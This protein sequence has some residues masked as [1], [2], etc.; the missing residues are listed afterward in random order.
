MEQKLKQR[1]CIEFCVK[2]QI[3]TTETFECLIKHSPMTPQREQLTDE[4]V[5]KITDLIKE[6][7]R[8]TFLEL[9]QDTGISKTTIGR[10]VTEDLKLKKTPA[11]FIPRFL[12]NEQKL[13]RLETCE[14]MLEMTKTDLEWKDKIITGDETWVY[15]YDPEIKRQSAEWRGQGKRFE[16]KARKWT[17]GDNARP[18]TAHLVTGF[19]AKNG[20]QILP[21][22]PYSPDTAPNDFFL[23]PKLKAVL[24][25]RHFDT[26]DD[27]IEKSLLALK[28]IPKESYK[29]C[30]DNWEKR[31]RCPSA[32]MTRLDDSRCTL[33]VKH[34]PLGLTHQERE[35]LLGN[36]GASRVRCMSD[37]GRL[38]VSAFV[39]KTGS[40]TQWQADLAPKEMA[41]SD[42]R[43]RCHVQPLLTWSTNA[44]HSVSLEPLQ[45]GA[46]VHHI[47]QLSNNILRFPSYCNRSKWLI[48]FVDR[49][50][51]PS[52]PAITRSKVY[53]A[54]CVDRSKQ[55]SSPAIARS[56]VYNALCV[57]RSKQPSSPAITR[58][59]VYDALCVDRSKQPSS[60]A[61]TR[62]KVYDALCVDRSKQPSSPAITRSKVYDALCVDRSKQPSSPA[63]TRSKVYDALCVDRSKQPSSSAITRSKVYDALCVDRSKQPSSPAIT[64]SKVYDALCVDRSKQPSSPAIAR[65]KVYDAL[66]VDRSK[67]PSSSAITRSKVYDALC[68]DRSK[69][70]SSPAITRSKVYDALCVDRSKQPS[71]PAIT[72]S[73]VYDALCVDRSKQPSSPA[74]TRSKVYDALCVDRSKQPS[75]P[76]ITRSKVYDALC[77]DR[78]KQPSSPAI[79]RSKVYDALCVDR[80]KQPSSPAITRSKVYDALCVDRSKQP[81]SPAIARS[82]VYDALC[83]DR[84]KQPSSPAITRSKV[85]DALCVDRSKQPSSSA[86]TRS[87]VYD[88]LCVDRSKQPSSPAITRS[89]VYDALCVDRSKQPS[90]PAI[91]RSKVYDAL[92][93]D[94]SKQPSSP[95]ITRSKVYDAL[96]V[97]RSKQPSSPAITRSKVYDALCVDR[98]KQPSSSAI[99]RS[100]VYDALCVDR[101]KQPS[102]PAITRSKVYDAL[103]KQTAFAIFPSHETAKAALSRLHQLEILDCI[104]SVEFS[105]PS[106][107]RHFPLMSDCKSYASFTQIQPTD[108]SIQQRY[109]STINRLR[110]SGSIVITKSDK[111]NQTVILDSADYKKKM[112]D[113]LT[114]EDTFKPISEKEKTLLK[115]SFKKSLINLKNT[116]TITADQFA[117]FTGSLDKNAYIYG[118]PKMHKPGVPLRPIIAYHLSP[119]FPMAKYLKTIPPQYT[120]FS[121]NSPIACKI[122]TV[123]T[124][125][126]RIF[127]HCSL[128]IFKT[129]EKARIVSTLTKAGYPRPFI[130]RHFYDP[131]VPKTTT[132]HRATCFL[133]Y[134]A[135]SISISRILRPF[136]IKVHYNS[137]PSLSTIL[138][139]PITKSD[140][141]NLP[142]HSTGAVYVVSCQ[143][144]SSTYVGE[145]GRTTHIRLTEHKR[146]IRNKDPKS[147]MANNMNRVYPP[148][149]P[150]Q[151][152]PVM[153]PVGM[154]PAPPGG[155]PRHG[156]PGPPRQ[157]GPPAGYQASPQRPPYPAMPPRGMGPPPPTNSYGAPPPPR[158]PPQAPMGP[159]KRAGDRDGRMP[160]GGQP[161]KRPGGPL[162]GPGGPPMPPIGP[163]KKKKL[164][165]KILPQKVRDLVPESQAY[166]DLLA[167]ERKLDYTITRKR[168]DIQEALKRPMKQKRKLRIFISN[169][170]YPGKVVDG[171]E[172][173]VEEA[174]NPTGGPV[175]SWELRVEGRLLEDILR[176]QTATAKPDQS[177][178][179]RK[180]SSF[181]KSLVIELDKDLYGP[182]NH[183]VEWHRTPNTTETDGFQVKRPGDKN[184]RCTILLL[185]DYQFK[186]GNFDLEDEERPGASPKFEGKELEAWLD[187]VPTQIQKEPAKALG[188]T[189][190]AIFHHLKEM[191]MIQKL[192][193][194]Y[195]E[196]L[197]PNERIT[198]EVY[199]RQL[200]HLSQAL[201]GKLLQY[202]IRHDKYYGI[203]RPGGPVENPYCKDKPLQFKLDSRLARLLGIH[204]QTRPQIISALWQYI[205]THRLQDLNEREYINCDKYLEQ[206]K[207]KLR[208]FISNTFYPGK[209][210]DGAEPGVEEATNPTGGPV[211]SWELRVEGRL[212]EDILREQTATAKPDQSKVKRKFSS[213]FKSL[214]IELDKDLYGPD[215]HLVEWHR[216]PNT[217]ETDGFQVKRPGDK[218]VRCTILLLLDYQLGVIYY[219]L[220]HPNERITGEVYR[221]Q[222]MHLSQALRGKLLQY[223][224][225]HDKVIIDD[226][227]LP[228]AAAP[229][230]TYLETLKWKVLPHRPYSPDIA[231]SDYYLF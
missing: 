43:N 163:K 173:G 12:T 135:S 189:Q 210:V 84:S 58:S 39:I 96:C 206:Q 98:S 110:K 71:S 178:V 109:H 30:F 10:I 73:K 164:A 33:V 229:I 112:M 55:P 119:A 6:N 88:A 31:W 143:D 195:Y 192:G 45:D 100:K 32:A 77:V 83:V 165:D 13:C 93:V 213:F 46:L 122:N 50:K 86:I 105:Q 225:R 128:P 141:P 193:V 97:D 37:T 171:A 124:L 22:P 207:R 35:E 198:G 82:K 181:F 68:V 49:S 136:G 168:L 18:H 67:Q 160:M 133:P 24:K 129:I 142:I 106:Q 28:S 186:S 8:T 121:S 87:K 89:K 102:S 182:D 188:V 4:N 17:N 72:R 44:A 177:K 151:G 103:C 108:S 221:R 212:L 14:D 155:P 166:M 42:M 48:L 134:S 202:A 40:T 216:T 214:V 146:N 70:P 132:L 161:N 156:P 1:I 41:A 52:S 115:K 63:I 144:C 111:G 99:T 21:Q 85:Y 29:N 187:E 127:T 190:P 211:P 158:M 114:D 62:S 11:K 9:E 139:H 95:A 148:V 51:Q 224:I 145:T 3:S 20:T 150:T 222:L 53:D 23:F 92:C 183:L 162:G 65:S 27:I 140:S 208:I 179:K 118:S 123:R 120:H 137:S 60:P 34:L 167:F 227:A 169:T 217:T 69:Q 61:I 154:G 75:S 64:R 219:E 104:L 200:M 78:S 215:N 228:H 149:P 174:T 90:S 152:P 116:K 199:R 36:F 184:V 138:R 218:N 117:Q 54:L 57:D 56:K 196:L 80:S 172:P 66:C 175:P 26:R 5:Q 180:F 194:I 59:K 94:R 220:L 159:G 223:A 76:A 113:I 126:K 205:K 25:G 130:Q 157:Y 176:E 230:K 203:K 16:K 101:S 38:N 74:I 7:P 91:T 81:S 125:S 226:K 197:H 153:P 231:P 19:L 170:F 209:V 47:R 191:G 107:S 204:T 185:L 201:R 2:L 15:G 131:S 79:T 147:A